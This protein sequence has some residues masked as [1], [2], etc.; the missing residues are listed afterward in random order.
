MMTLRSL[1]FILF[2]IGL[3]RYSEL[4][5]T[6]SKD[7]SNDELSSSSL[8]SSSMGGG[9]SSRKGSRGG[10]SSSSPSELTWEAWLLVDAQAGDHASLDS[11]N[12]LRKITPKSI[13]FAPTRIECAEGYRADTMDRCVKDVKIDHEAQFD[14]LLKRVSAMYLQR[15]PTNAQEQKMKNQ[16]QSSGPLQLSI[17]LLG[18]PPPPPSPAAVAAADGAATSSIINQQLIKNEDDGTNEPPKETV[19]VYEAKIETTTKE[20]EIEEDQLNQEEKSKEEE[21][22]KPLILFENIN[23]NDPIKKDT[24]KSE[25]IVPVAEF[26]DETNGS[27]SF[28]EIV[29]YKIPIDIK[30]ILNVTNV[31]K[32]TNGS[33]IINDDLKLKEVLS[34]NVSSIAPTLVLVLTPTKQPHIESSSSSS[35]EEDDDPIEDLSNITTTGHV[36]IRMTESINSSNQNV[37]EVNESNSMIQPLTKL[38]ESSLIF[39]DNNGGNNSEASGMKM[40]DDEEQET[41]YE[42]EESPIDEEEIDEEN[43]DYLDTTDNPIE[44]ELIE[45]EGE[46]LKHGEAGITIPIKNLDRLHLEDDRNKDDGTMM[47]DSNKKNHN[48]TLDSS[49][50]EITIRFNHSIS[51]T[52]ESDSKISSEATIKDDVII[53]TTLLNVN[54]PIK[55]SNDNKSLIKNDTTKINEDERFNEHFES[56]KIHDNKSKILLPMEEIHTTIVSTSTEE[57]ILSDTKQQQQQQQV[58]RTKFDDENEKNPT[59]LRNVELLAEPSSSE[60]LLYD[61]R[62]DNRYLEASITEV[63]DSTKTSNSFSTRNILDL[64]GSPS[65]VRSSQSYVKFPSDEINS[66]HNQDYKDGHQNHHHHIFEE[67]PPYVSTSSTKSSVPIF[68]QKSSYSRTPIG[69]WRID[70]PEQQQEDNERHRSV[71]VVQRQKPRPMYLYRTKSPPPL[72]R[73]SS[74]SLFSIGQGGPRSTP[75]IMDRGYRNDYVRVSSRRRVKY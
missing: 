33:E 46:I 50:D 19:T 68:H 43:D 49:R 39:E 22:E 31:N 38:S 8:L 30:A 1:L 20:D 75:T 40:E 73:I 7:L 65:Y 41:I 5:P 56:E 32:N 16:K 14:F 28:S 21:E 44:E 6:R 51:N 25:E 4:A 58:S 53:E 72:T 13:F 23:K 11:A 27:N 71:V 54:N 10:S 52:D 18:V 24:T 34:V 47:I 60:S 9:T 36:I 15:F 55:I 74:P 2:L 67:G 17:P 64:E 48:N 61:P 57:N 69:G 66:I 62:F 37:D 26:V 12:I 3:A 45:L 70:R 59:D 42:D 63:E 29:D 35:N